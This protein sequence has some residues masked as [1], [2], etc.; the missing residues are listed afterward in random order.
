MPVYKFKD[1]RKGWYFQFYFCGKK[2][3]KERW[4]NKRMESRTEALA[5]EIE[6]KLQLDK[7][8]SNDSYGMNYYQL[9][10]EFKDY[11]KGSLKIST[12]H[13][14]DIFLKNYLFNLETLNIWKSTQK[15]IIEWKQTVLKKDWSV[16][17]KNRVIRTLKSCLQYGST[18][19]DLPGKLQQSLLEPVRDYKTIKNITAKKSIFL[20]EEHFKIFIKPLEEQLDL[21]N[22]FHYYVILN[23]LY[24]TGIRIG[25]LTAITVE[26]FKE[27]YFIINKN[28]FRVDGKDYVQTTKTENSVRKVYLDENTA[29]LVRKYIEKYKP[30]R[31]L[32]A[33][34]KEY[35]S[36]QRVRDVIKK[37]LTI[38]G[39]G[40]TY[41]VTP[42]T[43]RHSH[44]SNLRQLGF[45]EFIIAD[46]LGNTPDVSAN[47]YIHP[48]ENEQL[49]I[50]DKIANSKF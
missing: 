16:N 27:N 49:N 29:N 18:I 28:Y 45:D 35:M 50:I 34:K 13:K 5:C 30:K 11:G 43:L 19:Y 48:K 38:T 14:Y 26:D 24:Y 12:V 23:I 2:I 25:E 20:D 4:N 17:Y 37:L 39:L 31:M 15:D 7:E 3:K 40:E 36:Q 8:F 10:K 44:A 32:F 33:L 42:H 41:N 46:R 47:T 6:C 22:T 1:G 9:F 21:S